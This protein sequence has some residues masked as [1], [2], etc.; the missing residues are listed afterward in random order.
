MAAATQSSILKADRTLA[1]IVQRLAQAYQPERI[2]LFGSRARGDFRPDS[3]YDLLM[4]VPDDAPPERRNDRLA[5]ESLRGIGVATSVLIHCSSYFEA[6]RYLR[7]S[8]PGIV[9]REGKL[10]YGT[11]VCSTVLDGRMAKLED[12][13]EWLRKAENDLRGADRLVGASPPL[14]GLTLFHCQQ[15]VEKALKAFLAW[16]DVP[17]RKTHEIEEL[18]QACLALDA[19]LTD[20]IARAGSL[21]DYAWKFRYPGGGPLPPEEET[22]ETI[23]LARQLYEAVLERLP[24]DCKP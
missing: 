13:K 23:E 16:H 7:A 1:N 4:I 2:Y 11:D 12:T 15:A 3:D 6:R 17:F 5:S 8:L 19:T 21:T 20:L 24:D 9:L 14:L 22:K 10:L 18:G